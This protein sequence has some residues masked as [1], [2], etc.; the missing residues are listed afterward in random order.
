MGTTGLS[1]ESGNFVMLHNPY[2]RS[3]ALGHGPN[4]S[5]HQL[6]GLEVHYLNGLPVFLRFEHPDYFRL[7]RFPLRKQRWGVGF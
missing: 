4:L 6:F 1:E 7:R 2:G 3:I 5:R